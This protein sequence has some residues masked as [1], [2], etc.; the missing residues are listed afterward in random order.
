MYR[1]WM[2][3]GYEQELGGPPDVFMTTETVMDDRSLW[4]E[5]ARFGN[6]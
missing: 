2:S 1:L 3:D 6:Q 4:H 5:R